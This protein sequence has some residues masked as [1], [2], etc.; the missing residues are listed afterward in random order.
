MREIPFQRAAT[1][2]GL[3]TT[4]QLRAAG[5]NKRQ[6]HWAVTNGPL[7]RLS[8]RL[9]RVAGSP[10]T[11]AQRMLAAVLD[12]G[13]G[14]ALSH[15]SALAWWEVPGFLLDEIH[16]THTRDGVH[17]PARLAHHVHDVVL[18]PG[19]HIRVLEGVPV[20]I[21]ARALFDIASQ[22]NIH[23]KQIERA[24][25]NAWA[26]RLVSG[27]SLHAMLDE[28]AQ[29]GRPGIRIM[30]DILC[31]RGVDYVPPASGLE[32]RVQQILHEAGQRPLRRQVEAGDDD[33]WIGRVDFAD[34]E[35]PFILEVHSERFHASLLDQHV[36]RRRLERLDAAGFVVATVS[37]VDVWNRRSRLLE[38]VRRGRREARR[39]KDAGATAAA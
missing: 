4:A 25:D 10:E 26:M 24:V 32:S 35:V 13:P 21:P 8:S 28:L 22:R 16:V 30:R 39:R 37:E 33:A 17:R 34:D 7:E 14:S 27:R 5:F 9:L 3:I 18:L 2:H 23:P 15:T 20:V 11:P 31:E 29:R 19:E 1:Q 36:D 12:A 38:A 6:I